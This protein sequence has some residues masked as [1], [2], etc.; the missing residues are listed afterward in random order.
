MLPVVFVIVLQSIQMGL[1]RLVADQ[2]SRIM[3]TTL[4]FWGASS[5]PPFAKYLIMHF[6]TLFCILSVYMVPDGFIA[7]FYWH[8]VTKYIIITTTHAVY[9]GR[10]S[11][12]AL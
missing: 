7:R 8:L 2:I 4:S 11:I 1:S 5:N 10:Y 12:T 3:S 9:A 6:E